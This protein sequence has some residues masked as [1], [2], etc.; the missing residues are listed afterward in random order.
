ML[1]VSSLLIGP[2]RSS[3]NAKSEDVDADQ[4]TIRICGRTKHRADRTRPSSGSFTWDRQHGGAR[5]F[6]GADRTALA[7]VNRATVL[8]AYN[9]YTKRASENV[10]QLALASIAIIWL[11]KSNAGTGLVLAPSLAFA[12]GLAIIALA[13]D[14]LHYFYGAAAWGIL[15]RLKE[16]D[17]VPLA[18]EFKVRP[19]INWPTAAFFWL[20]GIAVVASYIALM[21]GLWQSVAI[22]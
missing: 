4:R 7:P 22:S 1:A 5:W 8:E 2:E 16:L 3:S 12:L 20:K 15:N 14:F 19:A 10:R 6:W 17:N 21:R 13:I 18:Q 11:F 9:D